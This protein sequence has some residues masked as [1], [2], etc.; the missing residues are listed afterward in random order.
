[1]PGLKCCIVF[2]EGMIDINHINRQ[3]IE[4]IMEQDLRNL[5]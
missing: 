3:I 1:M 2:I 4:P 5:S